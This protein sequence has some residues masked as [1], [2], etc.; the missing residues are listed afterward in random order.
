[1]YIGFGATRSLDL[2]PRGGITPAPRLDPPP[3]RPRERPITQPEP[4]LPS[5][6]PS[7]SPLPVYA[8]TIP[9]ERQ[10]G[11]ME[12]R[13]NVAPPLGE[14][15]R[16]TEGGPS[17]EQR[18]P[19]VHGKPVKTAKPA[20]KGKPFTGHD[21]GLHLG[22]K[23][24]EEAR[25]LQEVRRAAAVAQAPP[26]LLS[27][28]A[29][30]LAPE[31][32]MKMPAVALSTLAA[33]ASPVETAAIMSASPL[34]PMPS[35]F[36]PSSASEEPLYDDYEAAEEIE[37]APVEEKKSGLAPVLGIGAALWALSKLF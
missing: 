17:R 29:P 7:P 13:R 28:A 9:V 32:S 27:V 14:E 26:S 30:T 10:Q 33:Q 16:R 12:E 19:T 18:R 3:R 1:M 23:K 37:P 4:P 6:F 20:T 31:E 24:R 21:R 11:G 5:V 36:M 34:P 8:P 25:Q 35:A 15:R 22:Q 2:S